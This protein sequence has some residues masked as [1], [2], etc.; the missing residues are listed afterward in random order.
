MKQETKRYKS[1]SIKDKNGILCHDGDEVIA[2]FGIGIDD[3]G[4]LLTVPARA[5]LQFNEEIQDFIFIY[6]NELHKNFSKFHRG[7]FVK[8]NDEN[9]K[10][11][12]QKYNFTKAIDGCLKEGVCK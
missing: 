10:E 2:Y 4:Q 11:Y 6:Q 8:A 1:K 7:D 5:I 12:Y 9:L 3:D